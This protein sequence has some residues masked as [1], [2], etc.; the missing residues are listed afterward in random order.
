MSIK[1]TF[2]N[3]EHSNPLEQHVHQKLERIHDI[4]RD[5]AQHTP[6]SLEIWLKANSLHPHHSVEFHLRTKHYNLNAHDEGTDMYVAVDDCI[7]KMFG[8]IRKEKE[9]LRDAH[10]KHE[11]EK[12]RFTKS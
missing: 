1:I 4:L 7:D 6:F 5:E 2:H 3:M 11:T 10:Q 12:T 8:Q 9:K